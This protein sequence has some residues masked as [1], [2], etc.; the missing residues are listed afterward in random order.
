MYHVF[1]EWSV[2]ERIVLLT[3]LH[4]ILA[5][6]IRWELQCMI[7]CAQEKREKRIQVSCLIS[8]LV[9]LVFYTL[10]VAYQNKRYFY[11]IKF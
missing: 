3:L 10:F 4:L 6:L 11:L 8:I 9:C 7:L 5:F 2:L 1:L